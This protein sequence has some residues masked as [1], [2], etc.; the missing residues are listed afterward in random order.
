[1]AGLRDAII[2][3]KTGL[4]ADPGDTEAL[5]KAII[6]I[7][8]DVALRAMLSEEALAYS[9]NFDWGKVADEFMKAI[10]TA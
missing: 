4:L 3:G 5:A 9:R 8:T 1:V 6:L 7:L 10:R 2:D